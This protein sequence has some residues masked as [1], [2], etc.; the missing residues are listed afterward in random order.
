V[1]AG[2]TL[3]HVAEIGDPSGTTVAIQLPD[4]ESMPGFALNHRPQVSPK[5]EQLVVW[6][7]SQ[8]GL[9][10]LIHA[11]TDGSTTTGQVVLAPQYALSGGTYMPH[12]P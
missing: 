8:A 10:G 2:Q 3:V 4:V 9:D 11:P 5:G 1:Q 12:V 7:T 6:F